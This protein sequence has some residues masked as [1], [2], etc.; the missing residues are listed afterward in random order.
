MYLF[1]KDFFFRLSS[2]LLHL[3]R[4]HIIDRTALKGEVE[5]RTTELHEGRFNGAIQIINESGWAMVSGSEFSAKD[6]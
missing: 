5:E 4:Y 1:S 6:G 3:F 2:G